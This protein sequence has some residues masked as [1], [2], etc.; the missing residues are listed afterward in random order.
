MSAPHT[1]YFLGLPYDWRPPTLARAKERWW[2]R[3]DRR[4]LT[5]KV[6]VWGYTLNFH[7]LGRRLHLI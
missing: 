2:N 5:P 6:F 1:G 7:E 4:L 3:T